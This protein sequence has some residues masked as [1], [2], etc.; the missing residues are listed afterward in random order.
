MTH[1][2]AFLVYPGFSLINLSGPV[3]VFDT[4][5]H[6]SPAGPAA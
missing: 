3:A 1:K 4:A 6:E 2:V 5:N